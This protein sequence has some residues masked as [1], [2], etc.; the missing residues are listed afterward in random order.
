MSFSVR[1]PKARDRVVCTFLET[2]NTFKEMMTDTSLD[3]DNYNMQI[4]KL[5]Q[6]RETF[7]PKIWLDNVDFPAF[8]APIIATFKTFDLSG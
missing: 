1:T 4:L 2:A 7:L 5:E 3:T 8:G 6:I